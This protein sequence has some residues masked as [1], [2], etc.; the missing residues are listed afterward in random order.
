ML[1]SDPQFQR[2]WGGYYC[3]GNNKMQDGKQYYSSREWT[4][5]TRLIETNSSFCYPTVTIT[6]DRV[7]RRGSDLTFVYHR[8]PVV[9]LLADIKL[10]VNGSVIG[11]SSANNTYGSGS[12]SGSLSSANCWLDGPKTIGNYNILY[13]GNITL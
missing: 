13:E 8:T 3:S 12:Y 1:F 10:L 7:D 2:E 5:T 11:E 9:N 6:L 4:P